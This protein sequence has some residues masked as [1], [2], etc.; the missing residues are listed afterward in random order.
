MGTSESKPDI[1][2][3]SEQAALAVSTATESHEGSLASYQSG[4]DTHNEIIERQAS[5]TVTGPRLT[6]LGQ[7]WQRDAG[8][9]SLNPFWTNVRFTNMDV[10]D[11]IR[12]AAS[13]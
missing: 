7:A 10:Y 13:H 6:T 11:V 1:A 2:A 8:F 12:S 9:I 5:S 3:E 4:P